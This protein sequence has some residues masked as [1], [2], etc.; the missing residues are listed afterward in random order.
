[1]WDAHRERRRGRRAVLVGIVTAS[2]VFSR[3]FHRP[4]KTTS[5]SPA[6]VRI[7]G[8]PNTRPPVLPPTPEA[9]LDPL[10]RDLL[11]KGLHEDVNPA[12]NVR[13]GEMT[14][15]GCERNFRYFLNSSGH[16]T[17]CRCPGCG[18]LYRM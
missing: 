7:H 17:Q 10:K 13:V 4:T 18:R 5:P 6:Q 12:S 9:A 1:M 16:K 11:F 8:G 3:F 14:C 15:P 2:G